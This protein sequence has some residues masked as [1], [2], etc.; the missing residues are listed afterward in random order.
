MTMK[1]Q[2][3]PNWIEAQVVAT[4]TY[5]GQELHLI[6]GKLSANINFTPRTAAK[7]CKWFFFPED[8]C[9][10]ILELAKPQMKEVSH[11]FVIADFE[12][13]TKA[14]TEQSKKLEELFPQRKIAFMSNK[15]GG[16]GMEG[17]RYL[18]LAEA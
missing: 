12:T 1:N 13:G 4:V 10:E 3:V 8:S 16:G 18:V 17:V 14:S 2:N 7:I 5:Q 11:H 6:S 9:F 15:Y